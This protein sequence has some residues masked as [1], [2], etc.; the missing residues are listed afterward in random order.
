[1]KRLTALVA[2]VLTL[3]LSAPALPASAAAGPYSHMWQVQGTVGGD[4]GGRAVQQVRR[5][6]MTMTL[7][8]GVFGGKL[9]YEDVV[10]VQS[11]ASGY[12]RSSTSRPAAATRAAGTSGQ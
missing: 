5:D 4:L 6:E 11:E 9:V 2:C 12:A 7:A 8:K 3:A 1:V 10:G